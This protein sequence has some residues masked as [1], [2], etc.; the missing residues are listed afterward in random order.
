MNARFGRKSLRTNF[1]CLNHEQQNSAQ[2]SK[3]K[4]IRE[5]H[6]MKLSYIN[7]INPYLRITLQF[8]PKLK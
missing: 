2:K 8:C 3:K 6:L 7:F 1:S 4:I 5:L